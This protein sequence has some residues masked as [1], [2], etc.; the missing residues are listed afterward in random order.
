MLRIPGYCVTIATTADL[1]VVPFLDPLDPPDNYKS[2]E[3]IAK[4]RAK[5]EATQVADLA[6]HPATALIHGMAWL[7]AVGD[8]NELPVVRLC[9][10]R[11]EERETLQEFI[12][13]VGRAAAVPL[14]SY[15][16]MKFVWP[17]ITFRCRDHRLHFAI[18]H[19]RYRGP[20][21]DLNEFMHERGMFAS[22][23]LTFYAKRLGWPSLVG[24][25][26]GPA[27]AEVPTTGAWDD[28]AVS[29]AN[30]VELLRQLG[31]WNDLIDENSTV[32]NAF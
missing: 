4:W 26:D 9:R 24:P 8:P 17:T 16:G 27:R 31:I 7:P 10:T 6:L 20:N 5:A 3:V 23:S 13:L 28:L 30:D 11:D 29:L 22:K 25:L 15:M 21:V 1:S 19:D 14:V 18:K 2:P 32:A 12:A